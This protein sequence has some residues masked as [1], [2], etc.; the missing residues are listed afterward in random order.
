MAFTPRT[1][2]GPAHR[3]QD[4]RAAD[5]R[6]HTAATKA[7][8]ELA[9][10][11]KQLA[12][13]QQRAQQQDEA[14]AAL[15]E[16]LEAA[17]AATLVVGAAVTCIGLGMPEGTAGEIIEVM[18]DGERLETRAIPPGS[19]NQPVRF[20]W[21]HTLQLHKGQ[22]AWDALAR[23]VSAWAVSS[24]ASLSLRCTLSLRC[25]YP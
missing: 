3:A 15:R 5:A 19:G 14:V 11:E 10:L 16:E 6:H 24:S 18:E 17:H 1:A 8:D 13:G 2:R 23:A 22:P 7:A 12:E 4:A 25:H 20:N 9:K 21:N